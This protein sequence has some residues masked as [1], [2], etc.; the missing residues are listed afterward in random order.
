MINVNIRYCYLYPNV[1]HRFVS[2]IAGPFALLEGD[3]APAVQPQFDMARLLDALQ[4]CQV[5]VFP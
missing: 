5:K 3:T 1:G 2:N 4:R